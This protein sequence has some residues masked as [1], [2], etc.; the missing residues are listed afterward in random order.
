[1]TIQ[2]RFIMRAHF[3][4]K[5]DIEI[6]GERASIGRGPTCD[7]RIDE[8]GMP[9]SMGIAVVSMGEIFL[10]ADSEEKPFIVNGQACQRKVLRHGDII[11]FS[12][13]EMEFEHRP[14]I[15]PTN[16]APLKASMALAPAPASVEA[17]DFVSASL[18]DELLDLARRTTPHSAGDGD[19]QEGLRGQEEE[20]AAAMAEF[21]DQ[22]A[23]PGDSSSAWSGKAWAKLIPIHDPD[24]QEMLVSSP[25]AMLDFGKSKATLS[26]RR[27]QC[28]ATLVSGI[29]FCA[30]ERLG[31]KPKLLSDNEL[32]AS[33]GKIYLLRLAKSF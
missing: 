14:S 30:K 26:R 29:V 13:C 15:A 28:Y 33:E 18:E 32:I 2:P 1:M 21:A 25:L 20:E 3:G 4:A 22:L 24:Q 23:Q 31:S 8:P 11:T 27:G 17:K 19:E 6:L 5:L 12:Q 9:P 16:K 7:I 10:V